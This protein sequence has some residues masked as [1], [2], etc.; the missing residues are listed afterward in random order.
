VIPFARDFDFVERGTTLDQL[1]QICAAPD[2]RV[3]LVGLG[4]VG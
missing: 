2:A 3:A 1:Q 4:G